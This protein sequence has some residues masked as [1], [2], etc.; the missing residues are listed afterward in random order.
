MDRQSNT[1]QSDFD[2]TGLDQQWTSG[3]RYHP[4]R[5]DRHEIRLIHVQ[6]LQSPDDR[7]RCS[8]RHA[9]LE[10]SPQYTA[11]SYV[12]GDRNVTV[13]ILLDQHELQVTA[14]LDSAL[15]HLALDCNR[16][17]STELVLWVDA[18]CIDQ[19]NNSERS[20]QVSQMDKVYKEASQTI[21][22]LGSPSADSDLA[23][24]SLREM[25]RTADQKFYRLIKSWSH[26]QFNERPPAGSRGYVV[27]RALNVI[28]EELCDRSYRKLNAL[29]SLFDRA[30]FRRVWVIQ[31]RVLSIDPVIFCG[32]N[33]ITWRQF[34]SGFWVL[35]G[36]RD[37][38]NMVTDTGSEGRPSLAAFL[39]S[40]LTNVTPVAYA[41]ANQPLINLITVLY[42]NSNE[43]RLQA[44]DERDY[45]YS[46]LGLVDAD[47][48][49]KIRADYSSD[50]VTVRT[51]VA[52][53]CLIYY[54]LAVLSLCSISSSPETPGGTPA[55]S[56]APDLARKTLLPPL[57]VTSRFIA[58][59]GGRSQAY[60][61]C[62]WTGQDVYDESFDSQN[63]LHL[64]AM[65][66]DSISKPGEI[67]EDSSHIKTWLEGLRD[68]LG[69]GGEAYETEE[70]V[71]EALWRTP[72][73]D[74]A[75]MHNYETARASERTRQSYLAFLSGTLSPGVQ[76]ADIVR[77]KLQGRRPF[78][79]AR[80]FVGIGP[81]HLL[82][83]DCV[84]ILPGAHAPIILRNVGE[85]RW[86]IV[87]EAYVHGIMDGEALEQMPAFQNVELV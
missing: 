67:L 40:K 51:E 24:D 37:Y 42:G 13:P 72:I 73:A 57:S 10:D 16:D 58:R 63:R 2:E 35:T 30:W 21:I 53:A 52:R 39:T 7:V 17:S 20:H 55:P 12:W 18:V 4:L 56:W 78:R 26:F 66:F 11:L 46:L 71:S 23:F 25:S 8:L 49:P 81:E 68:L 43:V 79:T 1:R 3:L 60:S 29:A 38:L 32:E 64:S 65:Y 84:W 45:V 34:A 59:E 86:T 70:A 44:S 54:G 47:Y 48:S 77:D 31:E 61:V 69:D 83:K 62:K 22:W 14:N 85:R 6:A 5:T 41:A 74:R 19:A 28:L 15:R 33:F 75:L 27:Q 36:L 80:G 76:Y 9:F 82:E 50:W 87:G